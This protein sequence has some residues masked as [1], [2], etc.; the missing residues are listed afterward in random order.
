MKTFWVEFLKYEIGYGRLKQ[1]SIYKA[2]FDMKNPFT[3]LRV[4][5]E[6]GVKR[7]VPAEWFKILKGEYWNE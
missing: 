7:S 5:C 6:D 4:K 3:M 2:T 1:F